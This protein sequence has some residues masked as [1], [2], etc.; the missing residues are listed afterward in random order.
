M[1]NLF[2]N[3]YSICYD[4]ICKLFPYQSMMEQIVRL[5]PE[6]KHI[7]V[8]DVGCGTGNFEKI[9]SDKNSNLDITAID[10]SKLM[11]QR[12]QKKNNDNIKFFISDLNQ[13]NVFKDNSFDVIVCI[14]VLYIL[15]NP[16]QLVNEL[17]RMLCNGGLLIISTPKQQPKMSSIIINHIE[18]AGLLSLFSIVMPLLFIGLFNLIIVKK[19]QKGKYHFLD[20]RAICRLINGSEIFSTYAD[21]N[22]LTIWKKEEKNDSYK[23]AKVQI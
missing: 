12:A 10:N 2:W 20:E 13:K 9:I 4:A 15:P 7:K 18:N 3:L 21:Q 22:W 14:N 16:K 1:N 19:G 17:K 23:I 6:N 5:I 11:I 8:L